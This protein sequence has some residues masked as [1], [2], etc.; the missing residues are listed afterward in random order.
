MI[1]AN[2]QKYTKQTK[3]SKTSK[4]SSNTAR[5]VV[6]QDAT[7][8]MSEANRAKTPSIDPR[9]WLRE[10]DI[11]SPFC[12][13]HH[14]KHHSSQCYI[15]INLQFCEFCA[16]WTSRPRQFTTH[17]IR[18][19]RALQMRHLQRLDTAK[20]GK[21]LRSKPKS[22][23]VGI[24]LISSAQSKME[25]RK[26]Y[27]AGTLVV[28]SWEDQMG[29][30]G[31]KLESDIQAAGSWK[32]QKTKD[33]RRDAKTD[34]GRSLRMMIGRRFKRLGKTTRLQYLKASSNCI[35]QST[36]WPEP[37][38]R[39]AT[40]TYQGPTTSHFK[41]CA[42]QDPPRIPLKDTPALPDAGFHNQTWMYH[43]VPGL[44]QFCNPTAVRGPNFRST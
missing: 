9:A 23:Y 28:E 34:M 12:D 27:G 15:W 39:P 5:I 14:N 8:T 20:R 36:P 30:H 19:I 4:R 21:V 26:S 24:S 31:K 38:P 11:R 3:T 29:W 6:Q 16:T 42:V 37:I 10:W 40:P 43:D 35:P 17:W 1:A 2:T 7:T 44:T 25:R 22:R 33:W 18:R 13:K 41:N 32:Q